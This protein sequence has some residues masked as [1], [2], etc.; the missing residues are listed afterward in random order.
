M[1]DEDEYFKQFYNFLLENE[2]SFHSW[3][4]FP[5]DKIDKLPIRI[6]TGFDINHNLVICI[7]KLHKEMSAPLYRKRIKDFMKLKEF[8]T[9]I[10]EM[11][12]NNEI[13]IF[14]DKPLINHG[15]IFKCDNL[16]LKTLECPI[17][18]EKTDCKT[19]CRHPLCVR[20]ETQLFINKKATCPLCRKCLSYCHHEVEEGPDS[21]EEIIVDEED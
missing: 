9:T 20:C 1:T 15:D 2:K 4:P 16:E 19:K 6:E 8:I 21:D 3:S 17:C 10:K 12:F 14:P 11:K 7:M 18:F 13:G 5:I